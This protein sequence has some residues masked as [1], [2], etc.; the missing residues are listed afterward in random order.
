MAVSA[1]FTEIITFLLTVFFLA[2]LIW[3]WMKRS[4]W[5]VPIGAVL[6][7]FLG[8]GTYSVYRYLKTGFDDGPFL[9]ENLMHLNESSVLK[10]SIYWK[11][12][13]LSVYESPSHPLTVAYED[14]E[15]RQKFW[16]QKLSLK[17]LPG[18]RIRRISGLY[19]SRNIFLQEELGFT[20]CWDFGCEKGRAVL[21]S[22]GIQEYYLSW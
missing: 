8:F 20:A 9:P 21:S 1:G 22:S 7:M 2:L 18:F 14:K 12:G 19:L 16:I 15:G 17:E 11:K 13:K 6:F 3:M 4:R 10:E 5:L